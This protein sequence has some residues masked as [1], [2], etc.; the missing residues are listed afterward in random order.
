MKGLLL[1]P[2][3]YTISNSLKKGFYELNHDF[4]HFNYRAQ[5]KNWEKK[6]NV[7]SKRLPHK[8]RSR[9]SNH[10]MKK[11]NE[12]HIKAFNEHKPDVVIIYNN[13]LLLPSSLS[14]FKAKGS[15]I[16]FYLGDNPYY[17]YTNDYYLDLLFYSDLV[18]VP[19]SFWLSQLKLLGIKNLS[20]DLLYSNPSLDKTPTQAKYNSKGHD[21]LFIGECYSDS[22]GYK[23]VLFVSKFADLDIEV[24]G[25]VMWQRWL[26]FFPEMKPKFVL[27]SGRYSDARMNQLYSNAK[28]YP[29]DAN[30]GLLNG[31]HLRVF[32]CIGYGLLPLPEY[33][34]D[35]DTVFNN[36]G[37]PLIKS[38]NEA[39]VLAQYYLD[40]ENERIDI[41]N[42][43]KQV[44]IQK[45]T[46]EKFVSRILDKL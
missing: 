13:E 26:E 23:R 2:S 42:N 4:Y 46:P 36:T 15:K 18:V 1:S 29:V 20:L 33:R 40:N 5:T 19:D 25:S 30:P 3:S 7:Q 14:L 44:L 32:D 38:Y 21:L 28:I 12:M 27:K 34:K 39:S 10:F 37:L 31:I 43:L 16:V 22:W 6:V 41:V 35:L 9:W 11:V 45:F 17:T 24:H 8:I